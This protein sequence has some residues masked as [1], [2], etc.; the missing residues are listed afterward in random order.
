[1]S[2]YTQWGE[3]EVRQSYKSQRDV[4]IAS[5]FR[6][7]IGTHRSHCEKQVLQTGN[8]LNALCIIIVLWLC[9]VKIYMLWFKEPK[10]RIMFG[11]VR[12]AD[13]APYVV[14]ILK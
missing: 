12:S 9:H 4:V 8:M 1:M 10:Y 3:E 2:A 5:H 7:G 13:D 11:V 14:S 6:R